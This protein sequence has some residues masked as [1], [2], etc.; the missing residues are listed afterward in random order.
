MADQTKGAHAIANVLSPL[1]KE[2]EQSMKHHHTGE[3]V[4]LQLAMKNL[5]NK[6]ELLIAAQA[7]A[8]KT[9]A[10][11]KKTPDAGAGNA[12]PTVNKPTPIMTFPANKMVW[13]RQKI[14]TNDEFRNKTLEGL[15]Q[16]QLAE[17][18]ALVNG[19]TGE[20]RTM[21]MAAK[22]WD[23]IKANKTQFE[24]I[25]A[26]HDVEKKEHAAK[27][28]PPQLTVEAETPEQKPIVK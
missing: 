19:K 8:K 21:A 3:I 5:D 26:E 15:T 12:T 23:A 10:K 6:I 9:I 25:I 7:G 22:L 17:I 20:E 1:L 14:K 28:K 16:T 24:G 2:L 13:F 4:A 27:L 18:N 11:E